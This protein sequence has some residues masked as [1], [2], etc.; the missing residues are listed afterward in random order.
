MTLAELNKIADERA[1]LALD[2]FNTAVGDKFKPM[3]LLTNPGAAAEKFKGPLMTMIKAI[4][5]KN[6]VVT[7]LVG[8]NQVLISEINKMKAQLEGVGNGSE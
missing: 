1:A 3:S 2:Q 5:L 7:H 4:E 8:Q 6:S